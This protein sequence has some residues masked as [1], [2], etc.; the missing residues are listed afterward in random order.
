MSKIESDNDSESGKTLYKRLYISYK[1]PLYFISLIN[2]LSPPLKLRDYQV[3][4]SFFYKCYSVLLVILIISISIYSGYG[5]VVYV[6]KYLL[7]TVRINDMLQQILLTFSCCFAIL[8]IA[9][10]GNNSLKLF[11]SKLRTVDTYL[12]TVTDLHENK[13]LY[14]LRFLLFH[15]VLAILCISDYLV[16]SNAMGYDIWFYY[17]FRLYM[18]YANL[19]VVLQLLEYTSNLQVRFSVVN[20]KLLDTFLHCS[21]DHDQNVKMKILKELSK[22]NLIVVCTKYLPVKE[23]IYIHDLLCDVV[24]LINNI[25]GF[26]IF[27]F[28]LSIIVTS[29]LVLNTVFL[30]ATGL[31][32]AFFPEYAIYIVLLNVCYALFFAVS[33]EF[34]MYSL[35]V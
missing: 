28:V 26:K 7:Q 23:L 4:P 34:D 14:Y 1:Y 2:G 35:I 33:I 5:R 12:S 25:Y 21:N 27:L 31:Q 16:W 11:F 8:K 13:K 10:H 15:L 32:V 22:K 3:K 29:V 24:E 18:I 19:I 9:L 6:Y 20:E 17:S 30:F